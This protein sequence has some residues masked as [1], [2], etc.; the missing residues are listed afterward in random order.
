MPPFYQPHTSFDDYSRRPAL[1]DQLR[2]DRRD[3]IA[4]AIGQCDG[5]LFD[6]AVNEPA[7]RLSRKKYRCRGVDFRV[8]SGSGSMPTPFPPARTKPLPL[9]S[10]CG[11]PAQRPFADGSTARLSAN[12]DDRW[13]V[14]TGGGFFFTPARSVLASLH[15]STQPRV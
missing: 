13:V 1:A 11:R 5:N 8:P 6:D 2:Q 9:R 14:S 15:T 12:A 4:A 7:P 10:R 3:Y